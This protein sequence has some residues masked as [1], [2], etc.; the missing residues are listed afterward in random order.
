MGTDAANKA[1]ATSMYVDGVIVD[2]MGLQFYDLQRVEVLRGPQGT[3]YGA[4]NVAG[5]VNVITNDPTFDGFNGSARV[6]A[7]NYNSLQTT[8][9]LNAT[10]SDTLAVRVGFNSDRSDTVAQPHIA[11]PDQINGRLKLLWKPT[12]SL[13]IVLGAELYAISGGG[14][15]GVRLTN[16]NGQFTGGYSPSGIGY[17]TTIAPKYSAHIDWD[18]GF[19]TLTNITALQTYH[20]SQT[21][22][23][24]G[25]TNPN[26][27][28]GGPPAVFAPVELLWDTHQRSTATEELRLA[29]N[30]HS[31]SR[32]SWVGG[33]YYQ[34]YKLNG[35]GLD[36]SGALPITVQN[37]FFI[38]PANFNNKDFAGFG[39]V[40]FRITDSTRLTGGFRHSEDDINETQ[41]FQILVFP[42][43][44]VPTQVRDT[45]VS[46]DWL[47]RLEQDLTP[48]NLVY[49]MASTGYRPG[50]IS[51]PRTSLVLPDGVTP[52]PVNEYGKETTHAYEIG[53]KNRFLDNRLQVNLSAYYNNYPG[54]QNGV[55][56][57]ENFPAGSEVIDSTVGVGA[58]IYGAEIEAAWRLTPDT[59][60]TVSDAY[61][62]ARFDEN[63]T[64]L[65]PLTGSVYSL[66]TDGQ[67][68]PHAPTT[69]V[70]AAIDQVFH[71]GARSLTVNVTGKY[72][73]AA[74]TTFDSC[75][76]SPSACTDGRSPPVSPAVFYQKGF[77]LM[78][79]SVTYASADSRFSTTLFGRNLSNEAVKAGSGYAAPRTWGVAFNLRF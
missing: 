9:V 77:P 71:L 5:S 39:Q 6:V 57:L 40:T 35:T 41:H 13:R 12:D 64:L 3:L 34:G 62:H 58:R 16:I 37:A 75:L 65:N 10:L 50:G 24:V 17:G 55:A 47:A 36:G 14:T 29:S 45:F 31:D 63:A 42:A 44:N 43:P 67:V 20:S 49:I 61:V 21:T 8:G 23:S 46:N 33:L 11:L 32:F 60:L 51:F 1:A 79:A 74:T 28:P 56:F 19:A 38:A 53:S 2:S 25:Y 7:G 69:Q 30:S 26:Y 72:Q 52:T 78:D 22:D 59:T 27:I 70:N 76:Y 68:L 54:F 73:S 18:M 15:D 4:S 66:A 48:Q